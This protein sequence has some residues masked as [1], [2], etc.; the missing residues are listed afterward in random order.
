MSVMTMGQLT[1]KGYVVS[2]RVDDKSKEATSWVNRSE[3]KD[4]IVLVVVVI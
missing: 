3:R 2:G 1:T 4:Q